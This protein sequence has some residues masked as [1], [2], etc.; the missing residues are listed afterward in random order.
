MLHSNIIVILTCLNLA[1]EL[2]KGHVIGWFNGPM[3]FGPRALGGRSIIGDPRKSKDAEHYES[4][5]QV[6]RKFPSICS[7]VLEE[8]VSNQFEMNQESLYASYWLLQ[9][10]KNF[11]R[12]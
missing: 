1:E 9:L 6:Q 2:E 8:D 10:K 5:N 12:R 7:L 3:E 4:K 11:V